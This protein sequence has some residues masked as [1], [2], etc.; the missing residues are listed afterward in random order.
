MNAQMIVP[1][2]MTAN[3]V[4]DSELRRISNAATIAS[5]IPIIRK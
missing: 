1:I 2:V 3:T 4:A 5:A